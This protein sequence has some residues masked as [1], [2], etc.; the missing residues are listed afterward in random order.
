M[1][2]IRTKGDKICL[3]EGQN[4]VGYFETVD[5]AL[6][7]LKDRLYETILMDTVFVDVDE[8]LEILT[9]GDGVEDGD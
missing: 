4:P 2:R 8:R 9:L 1:F 5:I 6:N 7:Y 3:L